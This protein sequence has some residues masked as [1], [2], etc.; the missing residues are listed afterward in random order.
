MNEGTFEVQVP[1]TLLKYGFDQ[2]QVQRNVNEWLVL[3]LFTEGHVSSGKAASLLDIT[4]VDFLELLRKRRI[5][6]I[7][8]SP[9][10]LSEEFETVKALKIKPST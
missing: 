1:A 7:D 4:R 8:Y 2:A 10:E 3:S 6:Y 5:A 9:E